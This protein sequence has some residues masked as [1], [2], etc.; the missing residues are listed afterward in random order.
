M[1]ACYVNNL[2]SAV[3]LLSLYLSLVQTC[4]CSQFCFFYAGKEMKIEGGGQTRK[5]SANEKWLLYS[6]WGKKRPSPHGHCLALALLVL[7]CALGFD[8]VWHTGHVPSYFYPQAAKTQSSRI[9][10]LLSDMIGN[11]GQHAAAH[12]SELIHPFKIR[13]FCN[14][15]IYHDTIG[16][17]LYK[18]MNNAS[19]IFLNWSSLRWWWQFCH[20]HLDSLMNHFFQRQTDTPDVDTWTLWI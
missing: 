19:C 10:P 13:L 7:Y 3:Q 15:M 6:M 18:P 4:Q 5:C 16:H 14:I 8:G 11:G 9:R 12:F 20:H 1:L 17:F 2:F